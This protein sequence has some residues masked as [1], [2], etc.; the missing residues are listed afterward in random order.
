MLPNFL[1][2]GTAKAATTWLMRS[3]GR[4]PDVYVHHAEIHYFSHNYTKRLP[5]YKDRFRTVKDE[6]AVGENSNSYLPSPEAPRRIHQL[7]PGARLIAVL[8]EPA[9]RAY[10]AYCMHF[11]QGR[12]SAEIAAYLD[13]ERKPIV[14]YPDIL[15]HGLY[16]KHLRRYLQLFPEA[17]I[18]I[19]IYDDLKADSHG[20]VG[21]ILDFLQVA[22]VLMP[23]EE[24]R[25][26]VRRARTYPA[27]LRTAAATIEKIPPGEYL[28]RKIVAYP[29]GKKIRDHLKTRT[30]HYPQL[31]EELR[32]KLAHFYAAEIAELEALIGRRLSA[33][34]GE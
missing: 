28:L 7:L 18:K 23:T 14:G 12:A 1:I 10:S 27:G 26:N 24:E 22:P 13:P 21:E 2:I 32:E 16:T 30:I 31:P 9:E 15:G 25:V 34:R 19:M 11:A 17:Q 29:L 33:W 6:C 8:R 4:H 5:W 20:F 3:L